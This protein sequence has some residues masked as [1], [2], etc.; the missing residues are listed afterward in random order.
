VCV[1]DCPDV[2]VK[3]CEFG[4]NLIGDDTLNLAESRIL[5]EDCV[6]RDALSDAFDAD[7]CEGTIRGCRFYA[8][9]NDAL[10]LMTCRVQVEDCRM[11]GSGDKGIS[12][13]E[14]TR[15]LVRDCELVSCTIG[16]ELKDSSRAVV[17]DTLLTANTTAVHAYQ[18]KWNYPGG[19]SALF[20]RCRFSENPQDFDLKKRCHVQ[21]WETVARPGERVE[22]V[23]G[24]DAWF[25]EV[26]EV[27]P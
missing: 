11:E 27:A 8:S 17:Y 7:R 4:A 15:A 10:D 18:K 1:Y 12:V 2:Q 22:Q 13:G 23:D 20:V 21:L 19:G 26:L 24:V 9:G 6:F 14:G 5:V 3:N 25:Q 16:I